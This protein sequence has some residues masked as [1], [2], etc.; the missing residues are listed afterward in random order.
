M[1][2]LISTLLIMS[3]LGFIGYQMKQ[4][5]SGVTNLFKPNDNIDYNKRQYV[6]N[7]TRRLEAIKIVDKMVDNWESS[8]SI[9]KAELRRLNGMVSV[10]YTFETGEIVYINVYGNYGYLWYDIDPKPYT[11]D[12]GLTLIIVKFL[13]LVNKD[14]GEGRTKSTYN[15]R[16]TNKKPKSTTNPNANHPKWERY[17][18]L[19]LNIRQRTA[20]LK[21]ETGDKTILINELN[22]AKRRAKEMKEKYKF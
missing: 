21:T 4:L 17:Y 22:S 11:I 13:R 18:T 14:I 15:S 3:V 19:I 5:Y 6:S 9:D 12:E 8:K 10:K 2:L 7:S 20:N 1:D 16:T